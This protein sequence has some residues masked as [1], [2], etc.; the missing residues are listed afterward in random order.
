MGTKTF[1]LPKKFGFLAHKRPNMAKNWLLWINV[2]IFGP[3]GPMADK[4]Q[5]EQGAL[6]MAYVITITAQISGRPLVIFV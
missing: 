5:C 3:F 6:V 2:G 1:T 4:K